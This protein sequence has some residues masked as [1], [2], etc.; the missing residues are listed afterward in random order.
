MIRLVA[1]SQDNTEQFELDLIADESIS[2]TFQVD[3]IRD[4]TQKNASYSKEFD[5]PATK[6]NNR[7]FE[8]FYKIDRYSTSYNP[9]K[10]TKIQ[11]Y[12]DSILIFEGFIKLLNSKNKNNEVG[13]SVVVFNDVI[14]LFDVIGDTKVRDLDFSDIAHEITN[15]NIT[16]SWTSTGV[17][18][19]AGGTSTNVFYPLVD[20]GNISD[21]LVLSDGTELTG[22]FYNSKVNYLMNIRLKYILDKIFE[23]GGFT[24]ISTLFDSV[25]FSNIFFDTNIS[26]NSEDVIGHTIVAS[27]LDNILPVS[28]PYINTEGL[29]LDWGEETGDTNN[30]LDHNTSVFTATYKCTANISLTLDLSST[31]S[32]VPLYL[33]A[34]KYDSSN[35]L[36]TQFASLGGYTPV[37][38]FS[39]LKVYFTRTLDIS[40]DLEAGEYIK[41][42][43]ETDLLLVEIEVEAGEEAT[44]VLNIQ[45]TPQTP[46]EEMIKQGV[47]DILLK[48]ILTDVF[49]MFN[50]TLEHSGNNTMVIETYDTYITNEILDWTNKVDLTEA[51]L[52]PIEIPKKLSFKHAEDSADYYKNKYLQAQGVGFG[53]MEIV[54]DVDNEEE[55]EI[56]NKVFAAPYIA[57]IG[58]TSIYPQIITEEDGTGFKAYSNKPRLVYK[59]TFTGTS[60]FIP[61]DYIA[62][63]LFDFTV[64][65]F[66][67]YTVNATMFENDLALA[68]TG[69]SLLYGTINTN[70][71]PVM[72]G[73][74]VDTLFNRFWFNYI[75][76]KFNIDKGVMLKVKIILKP[77]DILTF[78]FNKIVSISNQHFRVN[79]IEYSTDETKPAVVELYRI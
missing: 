66:D 5:L 7:F 51:I 77:I 20:D 45:V 15:S 11:L 26:S 67:Q 35:N 19:A 24:Y 13:Y 62:I 28:L 65:S 54:F 75:N 76:E 55:Q 33:S 14:G 42:V 49:Q 43:P 60:D 48:D 46:T 58:V 38:P 1:Y 72:S 27:E 40:V 6:N 2:I 30:N 52:E 4:I 31:G 25:D 47:G 71:L 41:I 18:L 23:F 64:S 59:R 37:N 16:N 9:Y 56:V 10:N 8:H 12:D 29:V 22:G 68:N 32:F 44:S 36:I 57:R 79:K 69:N 70:S 39:P 17:T 34:Y 73:Q 74:T 63:D 53:N 21:V 50:L 61:F 3:D 78:K